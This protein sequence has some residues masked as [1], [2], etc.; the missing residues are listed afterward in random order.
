MTKILLIL[1][2][3]TVTKERCCSWFGSRVQELSC[4]DIAGNADDSE[5]DKDV[6]HNGV[7]HDDVDDEECAKRK[8]QQLVWYKS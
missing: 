5:D 7:D 3:R 4:S 2:I 6:D 1:T 8:M